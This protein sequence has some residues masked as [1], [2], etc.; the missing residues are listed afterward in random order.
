MK[1]LALFASVVALTMTACQVSQ[2]RNTVIDDDFDIGGVNLYLECLDGRA[3]HD[4]TPTILLEHGIGLKATSDIWTR[5]QDQVAPFARVCR[6]DRADVGQSGPSPQAMRSGEQLV[7]ELQRLL[8]AANLTG[9]YIHV[10]H[11][12]GGYIVRLNANRPSSDVLGVV[13]VDAPHED[14]LGEIPLAPE[15]LDANALRHDLQVSG[16]LGGMPLVVVTR[17]KG[18][19]ARWLAY[20]QDLLGLSSQS[21][22]II[23][24]RSDHQI[25]WNQPDAVVEA[26]QKVLSQV[27]PML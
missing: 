23:A 8:T 12:F 2:P 1:T 17:G 27:R 19:T 11:S 22:Q 16:D 10:G 21:S 24:K 25:P 5:V 13:L 6:Y 9:P 20:Q 4:T 7:D 18:V 15:Q 26:I 14:M 3:E